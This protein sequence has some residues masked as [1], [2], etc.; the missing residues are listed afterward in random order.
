[1][2]CRNISVLSIILLMVSTAMSVCEAGQAS[3]EK[4]RNRKRL[5]AWWKF[6]SDANDS[7]GSNHGKPHGDPTYEAGKFGQAISLDGDDYVDCGNSSV[8]NFGKGYWAVS[9]WMK[10]TQTGTGD[11]NKGTI[12]ANGGDEVGGKRYTMAINEGPGGVLTLTTDDDVHAK[13]RITGDT[14]VNDGVWHHI[15]GMRH[16]N[17]LHLYID[18]VLNGISLLYDDYDLSGVS[19]HNAYI[20]AI[21]NNRDN[22]LYKR[23]VG[24]IDEVC[25][26]ACALDTNSVRALYSGKNPMSVAE[27]A[28]TVA[29]LQVVVPPQPIKPTIQGEYIRPG[30]SQDWHAVFDEHRQFIVESMT[31]DKIPGISIALVDREDLIWIAGFGYTDYDLKTPVTPD[32]IF[33]IQSISKPFTCTLVMFAVQEGLVELDTPISEYLPDFKVKSRFEENPQDKITLRHLCSHTAGF[34]HSA[35]VGNNFERKFPSFEAHIRSISDTW[36]K[37]PVGAKYSYS[38]LGVDLA[39]YI[40]QIRS[41]RSFAQYMK[42]RLL[43]PLDMSNSSVDIEFI[44]Q[45]PNRAIGH[46]PHVEKETLEMP[47]IGAGGVYTSARDL[48]KFAQF[49]LNAGEVGGNRILSKKHVEAPFRPDTSFSISFK[50][51]AKGIAQDPFSVDPN[52]TEGAYKLE[53]SGGGFGFLSTMSWFPEYGIGLLLLANSGN[54]NYRNYEIMNKLADGILSEK[55]V[56]RID[57]A[58]YSPWKTLLAQK[59]ER[60]AYQAPDPNTFTPYKPEWKKYT[61]KYRYLLDWNLYPYTRTA[62]GYPKFEV[63]VYKTGGYLKIAGKRLDEYQ[64]GVFFTKDGDCLDFTGPT[65]LWKGMRIKKK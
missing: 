28:P 1:M 21:T 14:R 37:F 22:S 13:V 62:S 61:G 3:D 58:P 18:G 23:F 47:M 50:F 31:K 29:P 49:R 19:Q 52:A 25:V 54:Y 32:T 48:A 39:A 12:F 64:P 4:L 20:G 10:T 60:P 26:F 63:D 11:K 36:L 42:A 6:D 65:P 38:N 16:A 17:L 43:D 56:K 59:N 44:R 15:V 55:L 9:A 40:L 41:G 24:H 35:P 30:L 34:V 46:T 53:Y 5:V 8:L 33:S 57:P 7:A 51:F 45:H 27:E 2:I